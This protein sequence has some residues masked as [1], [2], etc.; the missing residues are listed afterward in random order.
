MYGISFYLSSHYLCVFDDD[1]VTRY[2]RAD[3][4]QVSTWILRAEVGTTWEFLH[5]NIFMDDFCNQYYESFYICK[6]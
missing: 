5:G 6:S 2:M 1:H 3:V 4:M